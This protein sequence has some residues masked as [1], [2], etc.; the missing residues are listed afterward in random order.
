MSLLLRVP[1]T[2]AFCASLATIAPGVALGEPY[3]RLIVEVGADA[4]R[5]VD[6]RVTGRLV[7][8]ETADVDVPGPPNV[9]PRPPLYFRILGRAEEALRVEL[10]E[11]GRPCGARSVSSVGTSSL[12]AR[13]IALAAAELARQLRRRRL[14]ELAAARPLPSGGRTPESTRAGAPIYGRF[15]W[16]ASA[17]GASVGAGD[18]WLIGPGVDATLRF[19]S[20][21]RLSLGA[22]WLV[23][24]APLLGGGARWLEASLSFA[25]ALPVTRT[26]DLQLGLG[27][28]A[29]SVRLEQPGGAGG[30]PLD[31]W[32]SRGFA[33]ARADARLS[34]TLSLAFGPDIGVVLRPIPVTGPGG[35]AL[36]LGGLWLGGALTLSVDPQAP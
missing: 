4:S 13:H 8:L 6:S 21:Q 15:L 32:S 28:S 14:V 3:E 30:A 36:R 9:S 31:T 16:S 24:K 19:S 7:A 18:A 33:F 1:W 20:G 23:G 11:L 27:A 29:A 12:R 10:W 5:L 2:L 34:R 25:Q 35:G 26:F 22:A 17:R